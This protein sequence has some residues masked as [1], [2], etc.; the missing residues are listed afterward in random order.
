MAN[1]LMK[2]DGR[3][4]ALFALAVAMMVALVVAWRID[5]EAT[6][7]P[8]EQSFTIAV[9]TEHGEP[10]SG[11]I[12]TLGD[13]SLVTGDDG[14]IQVELR[15]PELATVQATGMLADAVVVGTPN[16]S[17]V[18]LRLLAANG[19][20][21]RRTV[22]HFGGDFMLGRRYL[23]SEGDDP[24][25][26]SDPQSARAV[27]AD[28]APL[29]ALADLTSVNLESVIGTLA[30]EDAYPGK[31]YLLQSPP[32]TMAALDELG[33]DLVTLGNNHS[34]DWREAGV[35]STLRNLELAGIAHVGAG[36]SAA[37]AAAPV[38]VDA[39]SLQIGVV[40][41]TTVT[42]DYVNDSL[43][44]ATAPAPAAIADSER[45]QYEARI[46]G[47]GAPGEPAFVPTAARRPGTMWRL[48]D[49]LEADLSTADAA[50]LWLDVARVYPELQDWV[51]RRGHGGAAQYSQAAVADSV[52]A[53]RAAGADLVVVQ[54]HGGYQ[55]SEVGSEYFGDATRAAVDAGADLVI[56]HHPHVLQGF[57]IYK[58]TLI[59]YSLGNIVFDQDF[60][61]THPSIMLR[62]VFE[63]TD[64]IAATVYPVILDN[65]RPVAA[66]GAVA[67]RI[68]STVNLASWQDAESLRLPDLRI[69]STPTEAPV[70]AMVTN[71]GGRGTVVAS[72]EATAH[73]V[74]IDA[75]V[76][77]PLDG[78]LLRIDDRAAGLTIG[79]D[80]FG[81]GGLEDLQADGE[82]RGGLEWSLP[83]DSLVIDP[84]SPAGSWVV[85]L[86]RTSQHLTDIVARTAAR[87]AIPDHRWFDAAGAP[88]D[89]TATYSLRVWAKRVGAGIPF[90]RVVFYE[91][92]DTDPTREPDSSAL[93]TVDVE[94]PLVNDGAWHEIWVDIPR[95]P[96]TTNTALVGLGLAPP[97]SQSG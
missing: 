73:A 76:P 63:G 44:D 71:D 50:D 81:Y 66:S 79:R 35:A 43:P 53:A 31:R 14:K 27:V 82:P 2:T 8:P 46:F 52:G 85:R 67:D 16:E 11:A 45:W 51:A 83:A 37:E 77:T 72:R 12:V 61:A 22:M 19:P 40:S 56:G 49:S 69:G 32:D 58:D 74:E 90:A 95:P 97:E 62:T 87:V 88:I 93:E 10:V 29:F 6:T 91:F 4:A 23:A 75:A 25:L 96:P 94:L 15:S 70:T 59:A 92:D 41:M 28:I 68:L 30:H 89:G 20:G 42:G 18:S 13:S 17:E 5:A 9:L 78:G 80:V 36:T 24:P 48:F 38:V 7:T 54:L 55:F 33:V 64:L 3:T 60:L 86:D 21:G 57:E 39:G 26:V 84:E 47:F 65:Y 1:D 34:N